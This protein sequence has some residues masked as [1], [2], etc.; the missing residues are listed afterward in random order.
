MIARKGVL[1]TPVA[2]FTL[3]TAFLLFSASCGGAKP[4]HPKP[5][6]TEYTVRGRIIQLPQ[7]DRPA[8]ELVIH[9]E[10][11]PSFMSGGEVVG[12][13][14]MQMPFPVAKGLSLAGLTVGQPIEFTFEIERDQTGS[15]INVRVTRVSPLPENTMLNFE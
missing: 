6:V 15:P 9:H 4:E 2:L 7:P 14:S 1:G 3:L 5:N 12:M 13:D 10:P 11:V 8:S